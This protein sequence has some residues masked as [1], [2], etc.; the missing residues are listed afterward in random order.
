VVTGRGGDRAGSFV[1]LLGLERITRIPQ[2]E[3]R[4]AVVG[5][6]P[7]RIGVYLTVT[8]VATVTA[9]GFQGVGG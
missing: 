9:V 7:A 6:R 2:S 1:F 5:G 3:E 8:V 4:V